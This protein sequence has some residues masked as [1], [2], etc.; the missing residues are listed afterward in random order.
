MLMR[1][2]GNSFVLNIALTPFTSICLAL[3]VTMQN[4]GAIK[5]V[6]M[7][8]HGNASVESGFSV[9]SYMIEWM[10][11]REFLRRLHIETYLKDACAYRKETQCGSLS[12]RLHKPHVTY[13]TAA[14]FTFA[15]FCSD[16]HS[17]YS[18][19]VTH[20]HTNCCSFYLPW[21][22]GRQSRACPLRGSNPDPLHTW[23]NMCRRG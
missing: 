2:W 19:M 20:L 3:T 7:L 23:V 15:V 10:N 17:Q 9:N 11:V 5:F 21:R 6:L 14:R 13:L 4:C 16:L 1:I 18:V 12:L 22:N 8:S